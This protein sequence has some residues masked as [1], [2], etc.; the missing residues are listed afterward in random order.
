MDCSPPGSSVH[1]ILQA[2]ILEWVTI[3]FSRDSSQPRDQ[4]HVSC[5]A[6][7]FFTVWATWE[8]TSLSLRPYLI[9][10]LILSQEISCSLCSKSILVFFSLLNLPIVCSVSE[11]LNLLSSLFA[12]L[13]PQPH[14]PFGLSLNVIFP[15]RLLPTTSSKLA[16]SLLFSNLTPHVLPSAYQAGELS[17]YLFIDLVCQYP[18]IKILGPYVSASLSCP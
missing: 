7:R 1:G 13:H 10:L 3:P 12:S 17:L 6:G 15:E 14:P 16:P 11:P 18:S 5:I 8:A 4:T 9:G 2:R